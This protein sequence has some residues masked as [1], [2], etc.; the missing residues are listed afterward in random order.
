MYS[1]KHSGKERHNDNEN[2]FYNV[3][4]ILYGF[5]EAFSSTF[6]TEHGWG[7]RA[8]PCCWVIANNALREKKW[9]T[10]WL[11][12]LLTGAPIMKSTGSKFMEAMLDRA[13]VKHLM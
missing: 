7:Y 13:P 6:L 4:S 9:D 10:F 2:A 3:A 1:T 11:V 8:D 5:V 12:L